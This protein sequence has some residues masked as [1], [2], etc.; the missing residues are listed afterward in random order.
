MLAFDGEA[1]LRD[2]YRSAVGAELI[3][4]EEATIANARVYRIAATVQ[5]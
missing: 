1:A 2:A 4:D 5:I 3:K